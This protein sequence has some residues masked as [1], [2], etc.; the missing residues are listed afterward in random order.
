MSEWGFLR[1]S[2]TCLPTDLKFTKK[3]GE[4]LAALTPAFRPISL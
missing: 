2:Q 1:Q 3:A 4:G